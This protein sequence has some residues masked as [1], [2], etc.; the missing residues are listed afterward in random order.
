MLT[1]VHVKNMAL[2][3]EAEI[4]FGRGLNILTGETGAGKSILIGSV[5]TAL[6]KK[7]SRDVIRKGAEYALVELV[8]EV[9]DE[10]TKEALSQLDILPED[11]QVIISRRLQGSRSI[12]KINGEIHT[13]ADVREAAALLLDIH[14]QHEHQSLLYPDRQL[15]YLDDYGRE[16]IRELKARVGEAYVRYRDGKKE[17]EQ[18]SLDGEARKRQLDFLEYEVQEIASANLK[19]G[20]DEELET[21]FRRMANSQKIM[22]T[23]QEVYNLTGYEAMGSGGS[24]IGY[25]MQRLQS[26]AAL[27]QPLDGLMQTIS[28]IDSLLNDFNRELSDYM[29]ELTFSEEEFA[30]INDR[31]NL[32]NHLKEKYGNTIEKIQ[33]C[34]REKEQEL[35]KLH[36][37][38]EYKEQLEEKCKVYRAKLQECSDALS[39]KRKACARVFEEKLT[40][41]LQDL[42]FPDVRFEISF[43][44]TKQFTEKGTDDITF[45]ISTNPGEPLRELAQVVSGGELS[46]IMLGI[47]TL[48]AEQEHIGTL[49]FDEIDTGISGRTAQKVAEKMALI[50]RGCQVLCITHLPQIA[51]MADCH[52]E[53]EKSVTEGMTKTH[54]RHL[55]EEEMVEEL[56]RMLGGTEITPAVRENAREMKRLAEASKG[57]H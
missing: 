25:A 9:E 8:F 46:R 6:G 39:K 27:D 1:H 41:H 3:D 21:A 54:I 42:N 11:G 2:I 56:A 4:T 33:A 5:G 16:E 50:S 51:A 55:R 14:G 40:A 26:V 52:F 32:I 19:K 28:D 29:T 30:E 38:E 48:L 57:E 43:K 35:D 12:C 7:T 47:R 20:E 53:I 45:M 15:A 36:H 49:I 10:Q 13:A 24:A 44:E 37:Y 17:L 18:L 23:L 34:A 22:E 31:L